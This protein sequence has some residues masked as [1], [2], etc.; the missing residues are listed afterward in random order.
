VDRIFLSV[1]IEVEP[2]DGVDLGKTC[3][4]GAALNRAAHTTGSLFVREAVDDL[5]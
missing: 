5:Q 2:I 1:G 4:A 3:V